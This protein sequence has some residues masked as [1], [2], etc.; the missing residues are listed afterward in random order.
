M[1]LRVPTMRHGAAP[2]L[3]AGWASSATQWRTSAPACS[4]VA[5]WHGARPRALALLSGGAGQGAAFWQ[6]MAAF[7]CGGVFAVAA[8]SAFAAAYAYGTNNAWLVRGKKVVTV[9]VQRI[10]TITVTMLGAASMALLRRRMPG[11]PCAE[12]EED[13]C[14]VE[15]SRWGEAWAIVRAGFSEAQ[16]TASEGV[17]AIKVHAYTHAIHTCQH[18]CLAYMPYTHAIHTCLPR[19]PTIHAFTHAIHT[20]LNYMLHTCHTHMPYTH[21]IHTCHTHMP[22]THAYHTPAQRRR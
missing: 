20:C 13:G 7:V 22:Y 15:R 11:A 18:T 14:L 8:I 4:A 1:H 3:A 2:A 16:R 12:E 19:M 6:L 17:E 21:A 9:M 5:F 10:W